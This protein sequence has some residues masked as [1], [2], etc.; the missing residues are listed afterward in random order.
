MNELKDVLARVDA[1]PPLPDTALKLMKVVNDP[2]STVED[3]VEAVRYDQAI[4]GEVLRLCNSAYFGLSRTVTS[5]NDAMI[6]LGTVKVLQLVMSIH[7]SSMMSGRQR[8]YDLRAGELWKHSV[9]VALGATTVAKRIDLPNGNLAFTAGLLHDIGKVILSEYVAEEFAQILQRVKEQQCSF[10]EAEQ[11]ILGFCHQEIGGR[12][13]E[14]WKL[15]DALIRCIR[16][17][18]DPG[19]LDPPDPLVDTVYLANCVCLLMGI[20]LGAD[21]LSYRADEAVMQRH[22]LREQD[23][24]AVSVEIVSELERVQELFA[25]DASSACH[26]GETAKQ[27]G[28]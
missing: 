16:Y 11:H 9:A 4:T 15:P 19:V 24:E 26:Q 21:G 20:G 8:G 3:L 1:L 13:G 14:Q 25:D 18:H 10:V 5:L 23:L 6:R 28:L 7:T 27:R 2:T 12:I 17:H 22:G